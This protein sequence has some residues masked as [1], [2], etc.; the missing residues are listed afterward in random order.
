MATAAPVV[1]PGELRGRWSR[2]LPGAPS[3][4]DGL[5]LTS[6]AETL[7]SLAS[8]G[9]RN[10]GETGGDRDPGRVSGEAGEM[11]GEHSHGVGAGGRK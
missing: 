5:L 6:L 11:E 10:W 4:G 9:H 8:K 3:T 7:L 1:L 2:A